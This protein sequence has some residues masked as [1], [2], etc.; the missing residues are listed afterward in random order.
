MIHARQLG[1]IPRLVVAGGLLGVLG[2]LMVGAWGAAQPTQGP[3]IVV[4]TIDKQGKLVP[5]DEDALGKLTARL[6]AERPT[7]VFLVSHGWKNTLESSTKSY[8]KLNAAMGTLDDELKLRPKEF[9]PAVVGLHWPSQPF[10]KEEV[11]ANDFLKRLSPENSARLQKLLKTWYAAEDVTPFLTE[12]M[13]KEKVAKAF[14]R[15]R[16]FMDGPGHAGGPDSPDLTGFSDEEVKTVLDAVRVFS[17]WEMKKR[18]GI[19]GANGARRVLLELQTAAPDAQFHLIGHSFGCKVLLS[20]LAGEEVLAP[21]HS[22]VLLQGAVS[23]DSFAEKVDV[24]GKT[25]QAGYR[26]VAAKGRVKGP[27]VATFSK[28]D[29]PLREAYPAASHA[30]GEIAELEVRAFHEPLQAYRGMGAW[31]IT[32]TDPVTTI[33]DTNTPY[34]FQDGL[35][36]VDGTDAIA[37]HSDVFGTKVAW[38]IWAAVLQR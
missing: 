24:H 23:T 21:V 5:T 37:C 17:F 27:I 18:A 19:V 2:P 36:S 33:R 16:L 3:S 31:G 9:K 20:A 38:L 7:H 26:M 6:T 4:L 25:M 29:S 8:Q 15:M 12:K 11:Q 10:E 22:L 28:N 32:G 13:P 35:Y 1:H 30:A 34:G 14:A